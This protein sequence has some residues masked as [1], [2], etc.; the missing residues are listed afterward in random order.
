MMQRGAGPSILL[1]SNGYGEAAICGYLA[2]A[3]AERSPHAVLEHLRL[4][5]QT[6]DGAWP[7]GVGPQREMPSG[8]LVTY[9]NARNLLRDVRSGLVSLSLRQYGFLRTQ[10]A[11]DAI[12]AVGDVYCLAVCLAF[13]RRP[14]AFVATAKS[15]YVAGHSRFEALIARR[16]AV[17]FAR[18]EPTA[19]AL[20]RRG[21]RAQWVG[22]A[23]MDGLA[24]P[25][26]G[27]L[28]VRDDAVRFAVLPGS[29]RDAAAN[30]GAA[31]RRLRKI[32]RVLAER[33]ESVQAFV[34]IAES[35][36][37]RD[38]AHAIEREG[39]ELS[40]RSGDADVSLGTAPEPNLEV[41]LVR[42]RFAELL[43]ASQTVLGQ[44]GTAN[45][46][47]AGLGLPIIAASDPGVPPERVGWY[48]RRQQRLLGNALLVLP[49]DDEAFVSGVVQVLDDAERRNRMAAAGKQRMGE[50]GA[51]AK[52]ADIVVTLA[53]CGR[54]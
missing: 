10:R 33:G 3:I 41:M 53:E 45:E 35:A 13:A 22:N 37:E 2:R 47:A 42:G 49:D 5:G 38:V 27:S 29:R 48:R 7:P 34:S 32:A 12:V 6:P 4:V 50:P 51:A 39:V 30:A 54:L 17:T 46:Q 52:I 43:A 14:T 23:M 28:P 36:S 31:I 16:A 26:P 24:P 25:Q 18:D 40:S 15:E 19:V 11:R 1:V 9:G 8:G 44:A 21:V 20:E